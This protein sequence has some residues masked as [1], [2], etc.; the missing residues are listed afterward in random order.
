VGLENIMSD[1]ET[2][3]RD[4]AEENKSYFYIEFEGEGSA[5]FTADLQNIT[6]MQMLALAAWMEFEAK[7][8]LSMEKAAQFQQRLQQEQM[9]GIAIPGKD[10]LRKLQ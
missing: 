3:W 5:R 7:H 8:Q 1:E 4:A 6:P 2:K 9:Q 10:D